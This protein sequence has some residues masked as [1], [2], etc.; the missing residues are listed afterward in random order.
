MDVEDIILATIHTKFKWQYLIPFGNIIVN[1]R[2]CWMITST[3]FIISFLV[4]LTVK[5]IIILY[6]VQVTMFMF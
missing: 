6:V 1:E 3:T 5:M 2:F 4:F